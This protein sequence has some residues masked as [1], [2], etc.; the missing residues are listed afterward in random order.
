MKTKVLLLTVLVALAL[1]TFAGR[2]L[3]ADPSS[4]QERHE[5]V[6]LKISKV[7]SAKDGV[8]VCR[9]YLVNWKGQEVVAQDPLAETDY[10]VGDTAPV[11]VMWISHPKRAGTELLDFQIL[12][13]GR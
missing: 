5:R 1:A 9:A 13:E 10:K 4:V 6:E 11:L 7:F 2:V 3:Y 8:A 12:P